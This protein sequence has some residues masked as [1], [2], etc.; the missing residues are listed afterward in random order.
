MPHCSICKA[1]LNNDKSRNLFFCSSCDYYLTLDFN[2]DISKYSTNHYKTI[3]TSKYSLLA[4]FID[5]FILG[6]SVNKSSFRVLDF[7]CGKGIHLLILSKL[8]PRK[9][10][11]GIELDDER[12][13]FSAKLVPNVVVLP[14]LHGLSLNQKF[15]TIYSIH[16]FE[17]ITNFHAVFM[18]LVERLNPGGELILEVPNFKSIASQISG[19]F[20][21]H[22]TPEY[23]VNHFSKFSL[24]RLGSE[25]SVK[26]KLV[27]TFSLY[28][29]INSNLSMILFLLGIRRANIYKDL[30]SLNLLVI[31]SFIFFLPLCLILE[32]IFSIIGR[33]SVLR[34][35]FSKEYN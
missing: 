1:N 24:F 13:K 28:H 3:S 32:I 27:G 11:L 33:G 19:D 9:E 30:K 35:N 15:D 21:A 6:L 34:F 31:I 26:S 18:S 22:Y 4:Y 25:A 17:H 23:H 2:D 29:G 14:G 8:L 7:G 16:V 10:F 5:A 12:R 20:W